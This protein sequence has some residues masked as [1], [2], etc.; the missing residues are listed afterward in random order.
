MEKIRRIAV[1]GA[2]GYLGRL[3]IDRLARGGEVERV[4]GIDVRPRPEDLPSNAVFVERDVAGDI[5]D[6]LI[7]HR[8]EAVAH[9]AFVIKPD[10]NE[11]RARRVNVGGTA[12]VLTACEK[13]GVRCVLYMS[14]ATVYGAHPDNPEAL[15]ED[16][17]LRLVRGFQYSKAK[18]DVESMLATFGAAN[19][20]V[21][22]CVLR[23]C[24]VIGGQADNFV[25][26]SFSGRLLVALRGHDPPMQFLH[27]DD[28]AD[29]M[30]LCLLG[31]I[32]GT[33]N[34][35]GLGA[36]RWS[37][38]AEIAGRRLVRFPAA[39]LYGATEIV[40]EARSCRA[41]RR[42]AVW[43]SSGIRGW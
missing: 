38:M 25:A 27:E 4:L 35:G 24:P 17:A 34:V 26:R 1:T 31:R 21:K 18:V 3:L 23:A 9:L 30:E 8:I 14:S 10:R 11:A 15:T 13:A 20:D 37:E 2:S 7:E 41:V 40:V 29:V 32:E 28:A 12:S 6:I 5:A 42:G 19:P 36:V 43:I 22:V 33:Y 39:L 16:S